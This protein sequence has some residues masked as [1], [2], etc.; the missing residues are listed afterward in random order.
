VTPAGVGCRLPAFLLTAAVTALAP[1]CA[2][3]DQGPAATIDAF[4]A[5][6]E[7][8]DFRAAYAMTSADT[9]KR[10]PYEAFAAT[11][12]ADANQTRALGRRMGDEAAKL[13]IRVEV[14]L[15]LGEVV[16]LVREDGQW[17]ID[18]E[19]FDPWGQGSPRAALRTFIRALDGRRYDILLRLAPARYRGELSADK[20]RQYWEEERKD[21]RLSLLSR[22]RA[23]AGAPIVETGDEA[24]MPYGPEQEA[25]FVREDGRWKV[26]SP[27]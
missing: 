14:R 17:R 16:T 21:E 4:G 6:L 5:A 3:R 10:I 20:L 23:A 9:R 8:G 22:L 2:H 11:L 25:H 1:A 13:P 15:G 27:E 18:G 12:G 26:E 24:H 19:V 7:R